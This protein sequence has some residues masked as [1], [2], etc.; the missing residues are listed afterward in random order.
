VTPEWP[1]DQTTEYDIEETN[2]EPKNFDRAVMRENT[3]LENQIN[4]VF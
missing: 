1:V 2:A 4:V 3:R